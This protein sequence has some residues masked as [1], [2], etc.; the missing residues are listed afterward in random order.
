MTYGH[1]RADCLYTGISSR[2]NARYWVW[3]KPLPLAFTTTTTTTKTRICL[4]CSCLTDSSIKTAV[5]FRVVQLIVNSLSAEDIFFTLDHI[6]DFYFA[7]PAVGVRSIAMSYVCVS[8]CLS[9]VLHI[10]KTT[11]PNFT[12][13]S[14][15]VIRS[16]G[17]VLL[18]RQ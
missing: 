9:A 12:K 18:W 3:E 6:I 8:V 14:V 2:P 16:L 11:R 7:P 17:S 13:F 15:L 1:L 5:E 10:S 4:F